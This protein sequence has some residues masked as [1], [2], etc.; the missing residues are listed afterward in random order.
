MK[1]LAQIPY[2]TEINLKGGRKREMSI[3]TLLLV[4]LSRSWLSYRPGVCVVCAHSVV[5]QRVSESSF[6]SERLITQGTLKITCRVLG[7][8]SGSLFFGFQVHVS[9]SKQGYYFS[10]YIYYFF[11]SLFLS[12]L[13]PF[14]TTFHLSF[15]VCLFPFSL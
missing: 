15:A 14:H 13:F 4:A 3:Y 7:E 1:Y 12:P 6:M 9:A 10:L 11:L 5:L 8:G 2:G